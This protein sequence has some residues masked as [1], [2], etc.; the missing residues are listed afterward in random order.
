MPILTINTA[1][2]DPA[3]EVTQVTVWPVWAA[4]PSRV[5]QGGLADHVWLAWPLTAAPDDDGTVMVDLPASDTIGATYTI[6]VAHGPVWVGLV[7]PDTDTVFS[8]DLLTAL[9][10]D[11]T[12]GVKPSQLEAVNAPDTNWVPHATT[13]DRWLWA[14]PSGEAPAVDVQAR[15]EIIDETTARTAA[16]TALAGRIDTETTARNDAD[17]ALG[18][19]IDT[20]TTA[21]TAADTALGTRI[22][23]NAANITELEAEE[24]SLRQSVAGNE[25]RIAT[26]EARPSGGGGGS[27]DLTHSPN[28]PN[29]CLLYTSPSP[30][31][32]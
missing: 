27:A 13:N 14:I 19:R 3:R 18:D 31:D 30:R 9:P 29:T 32:S 22:D 17:T 16:D 4:D 12:F 24:T 21:R 20:E 8:R 2:I 7:M 11:A 28:T 1:T 25:A 5:G 26:L 6:A 23:T 15:T 10:P